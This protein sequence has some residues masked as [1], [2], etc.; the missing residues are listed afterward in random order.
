MSEG[1][2]INTV[3]I[4]VRDGS[5]RIAIEAPRGI[6]IHREELIPLGAGRAPHDSHEEE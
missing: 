5:V 6:L 3:D 4:N 1:Y 2:Q